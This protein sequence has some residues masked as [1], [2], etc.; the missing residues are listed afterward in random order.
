MGHEFYRT[1]KRLRKSNQRLKKK[2]DN[3]SETLGVRWRHLYATG[4]YGLSADK[5]ELYH[6]EKDL[7]ESRGEDS[8]GLAPDTWSNKHKG[9]RMENDLHDRTRWPSSKE[10]TQ[11]RDKDRKDKMS[12]KMDCSISNE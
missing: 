8:S 4:H 2:N 7:L 3:K 11:K 9:A 10:K 12:I 1:H 5:N 6:D